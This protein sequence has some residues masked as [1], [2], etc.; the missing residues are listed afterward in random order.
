MHDI[1]KGNFY[2]DQL[3]Q[4]KWYFFPH[5]KVCFC[6][7][8]PQGVS[9]SVHFNARNGMSA[10]EIFHQSSCTNYHQQNKQLNVKTSIYVRLLAPCSLIKIFH[11]SFGK[12][13]FMLTISWFLI[14]RI[15]VFK[16]KF[17][18]SSKKSLSLAHGHPTWNSHGTTKQGI[19]VFVMRACL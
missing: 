8:F 14:Y 10:E 11:L 9:I 1:S 17:G 6:F 4:S 16:F 7:Y 3:L 15:V 19:L 2:I 12:V 5:K 13:L 18:P